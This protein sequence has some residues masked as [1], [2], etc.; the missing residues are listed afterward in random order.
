MLFVGRMH[1]HCMSLTNVIKTTH[2]R[3]LVSRLPKVVSRN[4]IGWDGTA[5]LCGCTKYN[6]ARSTTLPPPLSGRQR[7]RRTTTS[8]RAT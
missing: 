8:P 4:A 5:M 2:S 7:L 1:T 6:I 3:R